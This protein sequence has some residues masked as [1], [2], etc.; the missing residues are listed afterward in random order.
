L[1]CT[2][3]AGHV[4]RIRALTKLGGIVAARVVLCRV[5]ALVESSVADESMVDEPGDG[6]VVEADVG[7]V[8][9]AGDAAVDA[10][11]LHAHVAAVVH[12]GVGTS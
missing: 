5:A 1:L 6:A 10:P 8:A 7:V 12:D 11:W 2:C 9:S 4:T 3:A